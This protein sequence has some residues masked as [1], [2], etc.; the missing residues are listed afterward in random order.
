ML[1]AELYYNSNEFAMA[2]AYLKMASKIR[3]YSV[4]IH[5]KLGMVYEKLK[6]Y[7]VAAKHYKKCK[8]LGGTGSSICK[9]RLAFLKKVGKKAADQL[10]QKTAPLVN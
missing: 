5:E 10:K 3:G 7:K 1:R 8:S 9:E 6:R 2:E 4:E